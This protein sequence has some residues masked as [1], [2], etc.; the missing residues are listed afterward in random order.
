[1]GSPVADVPSSTQAEAEAHLSPAPELIADRY[2]LGERV[3]S[4]GM[5]EVYAARDRKLDRAVALKFL[6]KDMASQEDLRSRFE[7]EARAA[8]RLSHG[9][10]VGV[11]D[12]G[13]HD[14]NPFIVMELLSGRTLADEVA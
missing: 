8:G 9:N 5:G 14:G 1:M 13:E 3:G 6:R 4:G 12:S 2:E 11:F 10:V 7:A